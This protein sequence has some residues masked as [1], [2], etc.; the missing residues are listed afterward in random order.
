MRIIFVSI[1]AVFFFL[2]GCDQKEVQSLTIEFP[3]HAKFS[4]LDEEEFKN[5]ELDDSK[6]RDIELGKL[7][8]RQEVDHQGIAWYRIKLNIPQ[9]LQ[10]DP[11]I[12]R[13]DSLILDLGRIGDVDETYLNG[14]LIGHTGDKEN[15]LRTYKTTRNYKVDPSLFKYGEDNVVAVKVY[16]MSERP[17]MYAGDYSLRPTNIGDYC[18]YDYSFSSS[19]GIFSKDEVPQISFS[20]GLSDR[21]DQATTATVHCNFIEDTRFYQESLKLEQKQIA[22]EPGN[23]A[24]VSYAFENKDAGFYKARISIIVNKNDTVYDDAYRFGIDPESLKYDMVD[25]DDFHDFWKSAK[26]AL[27]EIDPDFNA[28][29]IDSQCTDKHD[30]Y[31]VEMKSWENLTV[32]GYYTVPKVDGPVPALL[33]VPWYTGNFKANTKYDDFAVF[34]LSTRGHGSSRDVIN[35]GFPGYLQYGIENKDTYIYKGAY[36]DVKRATDFIFSRDEIDQ[37]RVAIFGISQGGGLTFAGAALDN[38][39]KAAAPIVPFLSNYP[40][41]F[42]AVNWPVHEHEEYIEDHPG[43]TM[44][45]ILNVLQYFD[46]MALAKWVKCPVFMQV[47]LQDKACPPVINFGAYN[48]VKAEKKYI[49]YPQGGHGAGSP[50]DAVNWIREQFGMPIAEN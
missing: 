26:I 24:S 48:N 17:G 45:S 3:S 5:Y 44:E 50:K 40:E 1:F 36:L 33:E 13:G 39:I 25:Y 31:F 4:T 9:G 14:T 37:D 49:V 20:I 12:Q 41:Y 23:T 27:S 7:W 43:M 34:S 47:G 22:L 28:I 29:K 15:P 35:P 32:R 38:R 6:W 19:N 2:I 42:K 8:S 46:V 10:N 18:T 11:F 21:F 30:V 16:N